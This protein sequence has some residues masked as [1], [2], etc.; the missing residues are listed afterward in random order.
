MSYGDYQI[1]LY[2]GA[3]S[4]V[5]PEHPFSYPD[6]E[7]QALATLPPELRTY[8]A[9]GA[10]DETT[11]RANVSAFDDYALVPRMLNAHAERDLSIELFG[12]TLPT[13]LM[14]A[15]V[16]V[17][18]LVTPDQHGDVH[19]AE[20]AAAT[21]VPF[22]GST[23]M[24]DPLEEVRPACGDTPAWFQLYTP[25]D[26]DLAAS[27]VSRAEAAGYEAI[28]VT[29]DTW[30]PGWRPRD[31]ASGNF[32]QLRGKALANYTSDPR[33][34]EMTGPDPDPGATVMTWVGTFG[35]PLTW[36]DLTWLRQLT[37]LPLVL[38]GICHPDD[39]RR[40]LD[41]GADGI[42]CS[43]HGGR[44]ANGGGGALH[45]LPDVV[46][47]VDGRAP[48]VFDS[49]VRTGAHVVTALA[50]GA[51]A[52]AIGRPYVYGLARGGVPG[53]VH[54]VRSLLAEADL[55]MGVDG[56]PTRADLTPD[57]VRRRG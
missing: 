40:A 7:S 46:A 13:P 6:L 23:L 57:A 56:Y 29:L 24:S 50:L 37:D 27:L 54:V 44:Q 42:Y 1:E 33:F 22:I 47:A 9:G 41:S 15:P 11:Q 2:L 32:P 14:L 28:V 25:R 31:L 4:G 30:V 51:T 52:V 53:G 49:G 3:L 20:V 43:N 19:G 39:A 38:K 34:A 12:R 48:V 55:I 5:L 45:W 10:G 35:N 16:G 17:L 36:D 8:I 26:R 18:G 21:G